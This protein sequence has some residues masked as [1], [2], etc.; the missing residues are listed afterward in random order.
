MLNATYYQSIGLG[1]ILDKVLNAQRLSFDD[2]MALFT[3]PDLTAVGALA[4]YRRCQLHGDQTFYVVNRQVNYSNICVNGCS[5][6]AFRRDAGSQGAF[7]LSQDDIMARIREAL[8]SA[9]GLDELHIV[10][11]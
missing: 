10:G 7:L 2:G 3:C 1:T 4:L 8:A 6:C 5:F 9:P 11:G